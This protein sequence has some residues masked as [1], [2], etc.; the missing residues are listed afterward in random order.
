[1]SMFAVLLS[2]LHS[3]L[4]ALNSTADIA[5]ETH[6]TGR[7]SMPLLDSVEL[8]NKRLVNKL[9]D[10]KQLSNNSTQESTQVQVSASSRSG[11]KRKATTTP[12]EVRSCAIILFHPCLRH[13]SSYFE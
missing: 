7:T 6:V 2:G 9:P 12:L 11:S 13:F 3:I 1:M 10:L 5:S 4:D 8:L